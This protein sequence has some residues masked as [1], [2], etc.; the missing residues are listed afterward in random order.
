[1]NRRE[2]LKTLPAIA[3]LAGTASSFSQDTQPSKIAESDTR[4]GKSV[5]HSVSASPDTN[6]KP[7]TLVKPEAEGGKSV[8]AALSSVNYNFLQR[9]LFLPFSY[10]ISI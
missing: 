10:H 1:M 9:Q 7:L 3:V 8:L 4:S 2:F 5:S 6:L